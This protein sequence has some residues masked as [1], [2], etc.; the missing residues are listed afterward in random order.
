MEQK[1]I[2]GKPEGSEK[3]F[4]EKSIIDSIR[5]GLVIYEKMKGKEKEEAVSSM[6]KIIMDRKKGDAAR[7][8]AGAFLE[9]I[10]KNAATET[11]LELFEDREN[12]ASLRCTAMAFFVKDKSFFEN[13]KM[14]EKIIFALSRISSD[15]TDENDAVRKQAEATLWMV[16]S[17][18]WEEGIPKK[19]RTLLSEYAEY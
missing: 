2:K 6:R 19:S 9:I 5:S 16:F 7:I 15:Y 3:P 8:E 14:V 10:D 1:M 4:A 18:R 13:T 11:Y 17:R 12:S